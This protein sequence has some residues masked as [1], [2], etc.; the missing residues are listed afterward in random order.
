MAARHEGIEIRHERRCRSLAG[1]RCNCSPAYRA[2]VWSARDRK[3]VRKSFPTLAAAKGWRADAQVQ[4][5]DGRLRAP[6]PTTLA[7]AA[8][9]WLSGARAGT[10][11]NRSGD[12]YKPSAIRAY[13]DALR[14]R[15]L[16]AL[17]PHRLTDIRRV[18]VQDLVDGLI[19]EGL[20]AST[21][22]NTVLPLRAIFRRAVSRGEVGLNPT[23]GLELPA[24]R[25]KRDRIASPNEAA[26]LIAALAPS[27]RALWATAL[28]AGLRLGELQA[29]RWSD[30]DLAAGRIRVEASWDVKEGRVGPKSRAGRR[31]VPL[32]GVLRDH[33]VEHRL[34]SDPGDLV[35]RRDDGQP[36]TPSA[37]R[38]RAARDWRRANDEERMGAEAEEREPRFLTPITL[39]ECRHTFASL[40]IAAGVNAKALSTY[41]GHANISITLDRYGHLMPG[42]EDEAAGL[43]DAY[44]AASLE[45]QASRGRSADGY[46][47]SEGSSTGPNAA[48]SAPGSPVTSTAT[49]RPEGNLKT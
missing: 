38:K 15:V 30:L 18:D 7:E 41:M 6:S 31:T 48:T 13:D 2:K 8:E 10:I 47:T 37:V 11:R 27:D 1:G 34:R 49:N 16:P 29:L 4:L 3:A 26:A 35:F 22:R 23:S 21:V 33:L 19:A 5:A 39:H 24:V 9:A 28:Y 40:M 42:S 36:F 14:L 46:G 12:P 43:L 20:G 44:L 32:A 17:G 25:G 45:Q